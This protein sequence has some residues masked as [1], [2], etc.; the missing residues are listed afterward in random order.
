MC[1]STFP[2]LATAF[3]FEVIMLDYLANDR[4]QLRVYGVES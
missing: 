4:M 3:E 2:A 1:L